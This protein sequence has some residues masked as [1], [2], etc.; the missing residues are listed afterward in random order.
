MCTHTNAAHEICKYLQEHNHQSLPHTAHHTQTQKTEHQN[1]Q[2]Y[3]K[4]CMNKAYQE[5][6]IYSTFW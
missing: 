2:E 5:Q 3:N 1:G 4:L 6:E